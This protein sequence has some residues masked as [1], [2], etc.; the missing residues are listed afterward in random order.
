M[1]IFGKS[2]FFVW[3]SLNWSNLVKTYRNSILFFW[4]IFEIKQGTRIC[5]Y[6]FDTISTVKIMILYRLRYR[7]VFVPLQ[8]RYRFWASVTDRYRFSSKVTHRYHT[9]TA[10]FWAQKQ[11]KWTF[12]IPFPKILLHFWAFYL[13]LF[14]NG[15]VYLIFC[16]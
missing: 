2:H 10:P 3:K 7:P 6:W 1:V 9:V 5:C 11:K 14:R 4:K 13:I 15:D 8:S 16:F 12:P